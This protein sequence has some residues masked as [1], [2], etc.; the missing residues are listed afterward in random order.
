MIVELCFIAAYTTAFSYLLSTRNRMFEER[1]IQ[2]P[3]T[4]TE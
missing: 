3:P 2:I 1:N 4:D